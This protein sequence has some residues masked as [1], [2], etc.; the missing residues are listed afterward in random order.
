V[1]LIPRKYLGGYRNINKDWYISDLMYQHS[2]RY[3]RKYLRTIIYLL[4]LLLLLLLLYY[5]KTYNFPSS[6]LYYTIYTIFTTVCTII[7]I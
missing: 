7:R 2:T 5:L 4:L 3:L 6:S 1:L